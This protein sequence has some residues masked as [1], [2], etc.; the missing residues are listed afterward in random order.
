MDLETSLRHQLVTIEASS[1]RGKGGLLVD[2]GDFDIELIEGR[3][4]RAR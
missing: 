4:E 3:A 2:A 1:S